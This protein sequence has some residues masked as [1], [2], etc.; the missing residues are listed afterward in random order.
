M[1]LKEMKLRILSLIEEVNPSANALTDDVD[2]ANKLNYLIDLAQ[3]E[4][5]RIKRIAAMDKM[6][7]KQYD[8]VNLYD[9][10]KNFYKLKSIE[11][12]KF[13]VFENILVFNENGTATIKYY[14]FELSDDVLE[15]MPYKVASDLLIGDVS[16][17]YGKIYLQ[18]YE[19]ALN[20]LDINT[21]DTMYEIE[22]DI[23]V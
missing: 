21:T 18:A 22:D 11:G 19:S 9:E 2:I 14:K 5:A 23:D 1:T 16:N 13:D 10:L 4:L 12:V 3:H 7:V 8:Q 20:K 15:I 6:D 17:Q